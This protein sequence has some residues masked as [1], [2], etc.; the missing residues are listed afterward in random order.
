MKLLFIFL[1]SL[2]QDYGNPEKWGEPG[3]AVFIVAICCLSSRHVDDPRARSNPSDGNT[4]GT[5]WFDLFGRLR[6]LSISNQ[7]TLY[8]IQA[9][10]IAAIYALGLGKLSKAASLLA[11]AV[12]MSIDAGLHRCADSYDLFDPIEDEV[13]KRTFWCVYIW[14]KQLCA[15][16]G[17]PPLI[18]LR[19]CDVPEPTPVDDEYITRDGIGTP[20]GA[21]CRLIA[22]VCTLRIMVV[23]ESVLSISPARCANESSAFLLRATQVLS[24]SRRMKELCEEEALLDEVHRSIPPWLAHSAETLASQDTIRITQAERLHCAEQFV[25]LLI[26]RHRFSELMAE[27]TSGSLEELPSEQEKEAL[28]AAQNS[29]LQIIAAYLH[30]ATK[31]LMTYCMFFLLL[32]SVAWKFDHFRCVADGVHVIHQLTQAGRTLVAVLLSCKTEDL[33]HLI[34]SGLDALR[35]CVSLLRRFSGRYVCGLRSGDLMEEFCR[36]AS[37]RFLGINLFGP[38]VPV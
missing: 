18:R 20:P 35:S 7:P 9:V 11:E 17:R 16:F 36:R 14:D 22:F 12:T 15:H 30:I 8:N 19:D 2:Y 31:G 32:F 37:F 23:L 27:R 24:P 33:Q 38:F 13:R 6:T 3:F 25:R 29:A 1:S 21:E 26:Y 34:P 10:L 5:Q 28:R 4:A